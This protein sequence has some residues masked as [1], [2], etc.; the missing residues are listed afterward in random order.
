MPDFYKHWLLRPFAILIFT[1]SPFVNFSAP[2]SIGAPL[3]SLALSAPVVQAKP[4]LVGA[5]TVSWTSVPGATGYVLEMSQTG[6]EATFVP[7][8]SFGTSVKSYRHTGLY[9]NQKVYYRMKAVS[10]ADQSPYSSEVSATTHA[11]GK[12]FKIMPLGDSNTEGGSSSVPT[13]ERAAYRAK[14]EQLLNASVSKGNYDFVGSEQTGS[15]YMNDVDHAGFGGARN[16]EIVS[17]LL[18]GSYKRWYDNQHMGLTYTAKYLNVFNP[19]IILLHIGTNDISNDGV[20]NSQTTVNELEAILNEVDKYEANSGREVT[21]IVAK[22]IQSVCKGEDCYKGASATKNDIINI[23]N[24][25]IETLASGRISAGDRLE[26]VDMGDAGIIYDFVANGG[27]MVDR[28]HPAMSGYNKMAPIW[29]NV[30]DK[31][32]NVQPQLTDTQAPETSIVSKPAGQSNSNTAT[33]TFSSNEADVT[34]QVSLNGAPFVPATNPFTTAALTD[35]TYTMQVR[36]I[37]KAGNVDSTPATYNW[38]IDTKAPAAP[39]VISPA[40]N[41]LLG[42]NKPTISGTAE[43]G[44]IVTVSEGNAI[45]G[46][47][48]A[49]A[50]GSWSLIPGT[51]MT[52]GEHQITAKATDA[53]GNNS[54]SSAARSFKIDTKAPETTILSGPPEVSGNRD[55]AFSFTSNE[56]GVTYEASLNGAAFNTVTN[57]YQFTGLEDGAYEVSVRAV[58]GAG[59]ADASPAKY[60]WV[61]DTKAPDAPV[62]VAVSEDRGP[63][64][65][66]LITS[67]NTIRITGTAEPNT[68]VSLF[69]GNGKLGDALVNGAGNWV[70]NYENTAL[71]EGVLSVTAKATDIAGNV[72]ESSEEKIVEIDLTAPTVTV[73]TNSGDPVN[74][75]FEV[76]IHVSEEV[77]GLA[78]ADFAVTN[79]ALSELKSTAATSYTALVTPSADGLV[80]VG[81]PAGKATDLAGN[82]N[83]AAASLEKMYDGTGPDVTIASDAPARVNAPFEVTFSFSEAVTE[84]TATDV[85]VSNGTLNNFTVTDA[86]TYKAQITPGADG[87][88]NIGVSADVAYDNASNGNMASNLL[89][90]LYDSQKPDVVLS[91]SADNPTNAPFPVVIEF[92]EAVA[93]LELPD[94]TISNGTASQL[95]KTAEK[96]Y[97]VIVTPAVSGEVEVSMAANM[98]LDLASNGNNASNQLVMDFD[99]GRPAVTLS[100]DLAAYTNKA[101]TVSITVSENISGFELTD[102]A[103]VNAVAEELKQIND[104]EYTVLIKPEAEGQVKVDLPADKVFDAAKNGNTSSNE[105]ETIYDVSA[106]AGYA[107]GFMQEEINVTNQEQVSFQVSGAEEGATYYYTIRSSNGGDEV[108]G[109]GV[110]N[111]AA[112]TVSG[113]QLTHLTDGTVTVS[114]YLEDKAGNTGA[115]VSDMVQKVTR[116]IVTVSSL[117]DLK[118]PFKTTFELLNLPK[119]VLV[120]YANGE[121]EDLDINWERGTYNGELPAK[122]KLKGTLVLAPKSTNTNNMAAGITVEVEPNKAP[123]A[124]NFSSTTFKPDSKPDEVIGVFSTTDPDDTEFTYTLVSGEG[125]THNSLFEVTVDGLYLR[126]NNGLSGTAEFSIRVRSTDPYQNI[127]EATFPLQKSLYQG[128][129]RIELVNAFSPD[130]DG[131][132]DSWMVPELRYF[133]DVVIE[134]FDRSGARLYHSTNPEEGWNGQGRDGRIVQ[135]SYFYIIQVKEIDLVQKGVVTILK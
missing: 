103:L 133:N 81:L 42:S 87:E 119:K 20:D 35:G 2:V 79:G 56:S 118:V 99:A 55:A 29:F 86:T 90:R 92:S 22:I 134:V 83:A 101:F 14:L 21:V 117:A 72:S 33:F 31:L 115:V 34:Y 123:T 37:D 10:G 80:S 15:T 11:Q 88:V 77:H 112:F 69:S 24:S 102:L 17:L 78:S 106:P 13:T 107:V 127:I 23:Y 28:L 30:L 7:L 84:F 38:T 58:D 3:A 94:I 39:V 105:L 12:V 122:Y 4:S 36:A 6:A 124:L 18:N 64:T 9:Y 111:N 126:S 135:G 45:I 57:S 76:T 132:N 47:A 67:D 53:A 71:P 96:A 54:S 52:E 104:R 65:N 114:L 43:S 62:V 116:N 5:I 46:T 110:V 89:Q 66:D 16:E 59:N 41:A 125:D 70:L 40:E 129:Q 131:I 120:T 109:T 49:S 113:L 8:K 74:S 108:E 130:G 60:T 95:A 61:I 27:D 82:P 100:A 98:V 1:V 48:T 51:A 50:N 32:L 68:T 85:T 73:T 93:G 25:K 121:K 128:F 63:V 26:L 97:S 19:D 44:G 75:T 91:T